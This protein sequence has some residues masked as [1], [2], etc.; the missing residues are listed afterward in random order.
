MAWRIVKQPNGLYAKWSDIVDNFTH[1]NMTRERALDLCLDD[2]GRKDAPGKIQRAEDEP[3]RWLDC[4]KTI[5]LIHGDK[6]H[7]KIADLGRVKI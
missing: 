2:L 3:S 5:K 6:E 1:L 7:T 4:L